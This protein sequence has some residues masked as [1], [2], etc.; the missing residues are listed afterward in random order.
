MNVADILHDTAM[1][2]YDLGKIAKIKGNH[3]VYLD[4][5][6]KAYIISKEA[7]IKKQQDV[8][9]QLEYLLIK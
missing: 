4:Y 9:D 5:L 3:S 8:E 7:A 2:Y 6:H 1:E